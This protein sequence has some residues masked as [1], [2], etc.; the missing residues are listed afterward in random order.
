VLNL[1]IWDG[2]LIITGLFGVVKRFCT[3]VQLM[4]SIYDGFVRDGL[5]AIAISKGEA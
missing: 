2:S 4:N 3:T 5:R 1:Q